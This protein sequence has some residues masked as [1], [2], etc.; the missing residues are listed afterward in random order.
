MIPL[1]FSEKNPARAWNQ[2]ERVRAQRKGDRAIVLA[3]KGD[4]AIDAAA[5]TKHDGAT[6][7][8]GEQVT[9]QWL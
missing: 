8:T 3:A 7:E 1:T 6:V 4:D 9:L 5:T 2:E